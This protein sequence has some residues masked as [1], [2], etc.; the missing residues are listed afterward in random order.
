MTSFTPA[1]AA[2]LAE[3]RANIDATG[4]HGF[5]YVYLP[6]VKLKSEAARGVL[7]SLTKKGLYEPYDA[8]FGL[9]R[10]EDPT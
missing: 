9:V 8:T 6:F 5:S 4:D 10:T 1:E 3:L 7:S 2:L